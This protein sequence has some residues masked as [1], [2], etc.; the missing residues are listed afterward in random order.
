MTERNLY[1]THKQANK[2][3]LDKLYAE[4]FKEDYLA[5]F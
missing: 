1:N 3:V 5:G 4:S 2:T